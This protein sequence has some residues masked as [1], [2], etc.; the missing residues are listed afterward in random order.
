MKREGERGRGGA[1]PRYSHNSIC[2]AVS[3]SLFGISY[4][5]MQPYHVEGRRVST[6]FSSEIGAKLREW[7]VGQAWGS[8][9]SRAALS[10]NDSKTRY[11]NLNGIG[12]DCVLY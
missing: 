9:Y 10:S 3:M 8:C 1:H 6:G 2:H 5:V 11:L 12:R 4:S 7:A